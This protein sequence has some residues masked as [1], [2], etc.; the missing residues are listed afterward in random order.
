MDN[1]CGSW[2]LPMAALLFPLS[3]MAQIPSLK[4]SHRELPGE[5][6][7]GDPQEMMSQRLRELRELHGLQ[8]Q[9][10]DLLKDPSFLN[11]LKQLSEPELQ[12]LREKML[13]GEGLGQDRDWNRFLQQAQSS[14]KLKVDLLRRWAERAEVDPS[15][16][17]NLLE[18]N[19]LNPLPPPNTGSNG[20][21]ESPSS[22]MPNPPEP[23]WFERMQDE[24]T[25]WFVEQLD[26]MGGEVLNA[27]LERG[28]QEGAPLAELLRTLRQADFSA[29]NDERVA[30]L[31]Q[32]LL[33]IDEL[34]HEQRGVWDEVRSIF[35]DT[36]TTTL[37][38]LSVS[39]PT[40]SPPDAGGWMPVI[41]SLLILVS[42]VALILGTRLRLRA[43]A[44]NLNKDEWRLGSWPVSPNQVST[45]HELVLAFEYVALLC[46]GVDAGTCHHR[47]LAERLAA[48]D[49]TNPARRQAAETLAWLYEQAR[50]APPGESLSPE[51]L[52]DA[53]HAL[54][55]FAGV[56]T[57]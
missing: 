54:R 4:Q 47:A 32:Y 40:S 25:K 22:P 33:N 29:L 57:I 21:G 1:R 55:L 36:P 44:G 12:R 3:A 38:H 28:G 18:Q 34:L 56:T 23:S 49:D 51:E 30:E 8:D 2:L 52:I 43:R 26:D 41:L 7:L 39:K 35:R 9:V 11:N 5:L 48:Q 50:Y 24:S 31:S 13:K 17:H 15:L 42:M 45:R 46:L 6:D 37:P 27:L 20:S 14:H 16:R 53:R 10:Q 19:G